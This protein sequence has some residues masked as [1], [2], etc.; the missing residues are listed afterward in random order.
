MQ[1]DI[2]EAGGR[3]VGDLPTPVPGGSAQRPRHRLGLD[4]FEW[5][6]LAAFVAV[7]AWTLGLDLWRVVVESRSWTGTDGLFLTDQMQYMAWIH[8]RLSTC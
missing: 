8:R 7:S 5:A 4:R 3:E 2:I 6:V 1:V